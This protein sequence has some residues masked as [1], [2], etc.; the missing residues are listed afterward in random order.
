MSEDI[1]KKQIE[2]FNMKD[3]E[4]CLQY[5]ADDLKVVVL[6][7]ET[8]IASSKDDIRRHMTEQIESGEFLTAKLVDISSNGQF[9]TTSEIKDDGKIKSTITFIYYIENGLIKKM[10][11]APTREDSN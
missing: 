1:V 9:V 5:F 7:E 3:V 4:G 11:G 10:W 6:P 2:A 8:L